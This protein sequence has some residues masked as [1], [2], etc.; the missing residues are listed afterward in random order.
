MMDC[1]LKWTTLNTSISKF[2]IIFC[3]YKKGGCLS[4][5]HKSQAY[6]RFWGE[7]KHTKGCGR[8]HSNY[9]YT[10][11]SDPI[12]ANEDSPQTAIINSF[13][14]NS[15]YNKG[16]NNGNGI[17]TIRQG[18]EFKFTATLGNYL[19]PSFITSQPYG[20]IGNGTVKQTNTFQPIDSSTMAPVTFDS[21]H[22]Q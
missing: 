20:A 4:S 21:F 13:W 11:K 7:G 9:D 8:V 16:S 19:Q 18:V 3:C 10:M 12:I 5:A 2:N 22:Y 6:A 14:N 15:S 17:K 1:R